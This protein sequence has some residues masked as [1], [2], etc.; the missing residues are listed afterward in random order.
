MDPAT[1]PV[2]PQPCQSHGNSLALASSEPFPFLSLPIKIRLQIYKLL[3]PPRTH[4]IVT[5]I[6]HSG[7]YYNTATIPIHS[8]QTFYSFGRTPPQ[9]LTTYKVLTT[10]F[11]SSFPSPSIYSEVLRVSRQIREEAEPVLY[12]GK[13]VEWD[14]GIHLEVLRAFWK[15]R[16]QIARESVKHIRIAKEIPCEVN[17]DGRIVKSV[18]EKWETFCVFLGDQLPSMKILDLTIW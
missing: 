5:Q 7:F 3:L 10:N 4:T 12:G 9:N 6:P 1:L 18:D 13:G 11:R 2:D 15:D 17:T 14:F 8:T 16:S